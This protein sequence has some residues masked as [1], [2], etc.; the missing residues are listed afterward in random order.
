MIGVC[1]EIKRVCLIKY[2]AFT[3]D[4]D[5]HAATQHVDVFLNASAVRHK[6]SSASASFDKMTVDG[7]VSQ[8]SIFE[9][10]DRLTPDTSASISKEK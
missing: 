3:S 9:I 1:L 5:A 7:T 8:R 2:H 4:R 6:I 10:M